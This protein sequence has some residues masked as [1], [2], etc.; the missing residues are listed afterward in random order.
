[1]SSFYPVLGKQKC[2]PFYLTGI[3]VTDPEYHIVREPGLISHQILFTL[4][5]AGKLLVG[6]RSYLL[7]KD[8]LFYIAPDIPHE[9]YP[10]VEDDWVTC[11]VVFRGEHLEEVMPRL[12]FDRFAQR[13]GAVTEEIQRIFQRMQSSVN[14]PVYGDEEC[15]VLVYEYIMAVRRAL[16]SQEK[17]G[18]RGMG[19]ILDGALVYINE[20]Y[21]KDITLEELAG[22]CG[23][24]KQHFCR[25]FKAKMG[26]R[27]MEYLARKRVSEARALLLSTKMPVAEIG[28][29][30][31]YDSLTY[32]G[33]VFKKYEGISPTDCRKRT[34]SSLM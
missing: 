20:N 24:T 26:M 31:G 12:G 8:S 3:G 33:M 2:L 13:D 21:G 7:E 16:Q 29:R 28:R 19:S 4:R 22:I 9:Y 10:A 17:Y 34:G 1:M 5:G 15:S 14:D 25:V 11:W 32:F 30:V 23:V 6:G 27:P 18:D